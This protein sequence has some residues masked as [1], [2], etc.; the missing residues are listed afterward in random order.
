MPSSPH[1]MVD[2]PIGPTATDWL[3]QKESG[4][5]PAVLLNAEQA[6]NLDWNAPSRQLEPRKVNVSPST[7]RQLSEFPAKIA[8]LLELIG[9][10][11]HEELP[12]RTW[13]TNFS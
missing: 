4:W 6:F 1:N 3:R 7:F 12:V 13:E 9:G 5:V 10:H 8:E 11:R 2:G